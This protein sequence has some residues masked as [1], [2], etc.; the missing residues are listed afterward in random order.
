MRFILQ[1]SFYFATMNKVLDYIENIPREDF[2]EISLA[3]HEMIISN[4]E[5]C[6][7]ELKW[8]IPFYM[9]YGNLCFINPRKDKVDLGFYNGKSI[10]DHHNILQG[11][12]KL[13]RH[14]HLFELNDVYN[15][16]VL[17]TIIIAAEI[18]REL[19]SGKRK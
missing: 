3:L 13:V 1:G 17:E 2:R 12:G 6:D 11:M 16:A 14:I 4:L 9:H 5:P 19:H 10:P 7:Y 8:D 18:N 15:N